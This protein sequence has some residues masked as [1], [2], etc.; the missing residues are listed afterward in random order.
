MVC[1]KCQKTIFINN[2]AIM[3]GGRWGGGEFSLLKSELLESLRYTM[4]PIQQHAFE[5][6]KY[7]MQNKNC[8]PRCILKGFAILNTMLN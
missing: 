2:Y 3:E 5:T 4:R 1:A 8:C 7:V 6:E